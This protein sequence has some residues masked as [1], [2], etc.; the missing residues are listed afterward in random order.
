MALTSFWHPRVMATLILLA[1]T[2]VVVWV[3]R[4][5]P[6]RLDTTWVHRMGRAMIGPIGVA[7]AGFLIAMIAAATQHQPPALYGAALAAGPLWFLDLGAIVFAVCWAF[8]SVGGRSWS[9]VLLAT[10]VPMTQAVM[11]GT[12]TMQVA[13]RHIGL[14]N[15]LI[16]NGGLDR[17]AGIY[18]AYSGLGSTRSRQDRPF[19]CS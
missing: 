9:I 8:S 19:C 12:P 13:A 10:V 1:S 15:L 14:V 6:P 5:R 16:A 17:E 18:Q 7:T 11:Y 4:K 2:A 3:A